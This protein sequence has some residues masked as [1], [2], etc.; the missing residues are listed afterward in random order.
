MALAAATSCLRTWGP[1]VLHASN[2]DMARQLRDAPLCKEAAMT[3]LQIQSQT[4]AMH[5][6]THS[7]API[8]RKMSM[9]LVASSAFHMGLW[10]GGDGGQLRGSGGQEVID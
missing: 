6:C 8:G 1:V 3:A 2:H 10:R 4:C 9:V 7:L 5:A